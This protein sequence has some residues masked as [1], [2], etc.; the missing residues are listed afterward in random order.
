M[1]GNSR[2]FFDILHGLVQ[3]PQPAVP[4]FEHWLASR[5]AGAPI[6]LR[7]LLAEHALSPPWAANQLAL[8]NNILSATD[9]CLNLALNR[10]AFEDAKIGVLVQGT[11][12][13]RPGL[14]GVEQHYIRI[15]ARVEVPLRW[16]QSEQPGRGAACGSH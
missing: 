10:P 3:R 14:G 5:N 2:L 7:L 13:H 6:I 9:Y 1:N 4:L 16:V 8:A 15:R 11:G 12:R